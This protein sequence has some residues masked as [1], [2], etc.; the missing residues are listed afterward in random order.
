ML[1][2]SADLARSGLTRDEI[3]RKVAS[4]ELRRIRAGVYARAVDGLPP[5]DPDDGVPAY[6]AARRGFLER[7]RA[8][9][10]SIEP[11]TVISHG[12]ALAL[13]RLPLY[14]VPLGRPTVTRHRDGRGGGRRSSALVSANLPLDG[15]TGIVEG[16]PVTSPARTI[17]DVT[18]T[19]GLESG[20][21]AADQAIRRRLCTAGDLLMEAEAAPEPHVPVHCRRC[22]LGYPN[23][24]WNR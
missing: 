9:A 8:A 20:V 22:A 4:G 12:S 21:C 14:D 1:S 7:T 23:R 3:I 24:C 5:G 11:G 17:I 2:T 10:R 13:Y 16:I 18:R 15:V 19:V 6:E